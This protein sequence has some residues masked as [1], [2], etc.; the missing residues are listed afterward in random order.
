M[1]SVRDAAEALGL[2]GDIS[3]VG[4]LGLGSGVSLRETLVH[5]QA[6]GMLPAAGTTTAV[7]NDLLGWTREVYGSGLAPAPVRGVER[8]LKALDCESRREG[9][10]FP[11]V[12]D[13]AGTDRV[14]L[15]TH[16]QGVARL[17]GVGRE[18]WLV[19]TKSDEEHG[20]AGM[21]FVDYPLT[22]D[23]RAWKHADRSEGDTGRTRHFHGQTESTHPGGIQ[24]CG[25]LLAVP[26]G[27]GRNRAWVTLYDISNPAAAREVSRVSIEHPIVHAAA[28]TRLNNGQYLIFALAQND[29]SGWFYQSSG[30]TPDDLGRWRLLSFWQK[31]E[32]R[33]EPGKWRTYQNINF[34]VDG[35][36]GVIFLV[37]MGGRGRDGYLD[38]FRVAREGAGA[39][40]LLWTMNR[41]LRTR[42]GGASLRAGGGIHVTPGGRETV[43]YVIE[44]AQT[45][46]RKL[47]VEEF[48]DK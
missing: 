12:V 30:T 24:V 15:T 46:T 42:M 1:I 21:I 28:L 2:E 8:A 27:D 36:A 45:F 40:T 14:K 3:A 11:F 10:Q 7:S 13:I 37:G 25:R 17:A 41:G 39:V 18:N 35:E 4:D 20:Q 16:A 22:S 6:G 26:F 38:V 9:H 34:L 33:P 44:K 5:I 19:F 23:G 32:L 43:L 29:A 47:T 31:D 48:H